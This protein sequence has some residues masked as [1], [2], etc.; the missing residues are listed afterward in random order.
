MN[1]NGELNVNNLTLEEKT[2]IITDYLR[3][4][5]KKNISKKFGVDPRTI[6][7]VI[8]DDNLRTETER[9]HIELTQSRE[10]RKIDDVKN[11]ILQYVLDTMKEVNS[12]P[13]IM[14]TSKKIGFFDKISKMVSDVD[15]ISRLNREQST[16]NDTQRRVV[17]DV[18]GVVKNLKTNDD[19]K[20]FLK[21][22][23]PC[24]SDGADIIT[25]TDN[26]N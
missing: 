10:S 4:K 9:R 12:S 6:T 17:F 21:S 24:L 7:A 16:S 23:I 2:Q 11:E 8:S 13:D 5:D 3:G 19:K 25:I 1:T 26:N 14:S 18:A 22:Q 15:K 20:N